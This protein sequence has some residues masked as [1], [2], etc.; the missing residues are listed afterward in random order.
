MILISEL[1]AFRSLNFINSSDV[2]AETSTNIH[3]H[4]HY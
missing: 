4:H 2:N 3:C 1:S